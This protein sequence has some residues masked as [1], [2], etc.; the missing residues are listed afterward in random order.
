M[1]PRVHVNKR[2]VPVPSHVKWIRLSVI[3][4]YC[5]G[6]FFLFVPG[7]NYQ[8]KEEV[9]Q[10]Y[11]KNIATSANTVSLPSGVMYNVIKT[12]FGKRPLNPLSIVKVHC[13][14][15]LITGEVFTTTRGQKP[16]EFSLDRVIPG[17]AEGLMHMQVGA[18]HEITIPASLGYG[19]MG[20][21]GSVPP[22]TPLKFKVQ[23]MSVDNE[24]R[25]SR[26]PSLEEH[27]AAG[28][29]V[30]VINQ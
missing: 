10:K 12:G 9:F 25:R 2:W 7:S 21:I 20:K 6:F 11:L 27:L 16:L 4:S 13:E 17:F 3:G 22:N 28:E 24:S 5:L 26:G 19:R 18:E 1:K 14:G 8:K 23:L 30:Y 15:S 29:T